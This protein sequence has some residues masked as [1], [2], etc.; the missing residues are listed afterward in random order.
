MSDDDTLLVIEILGH[1]FES[2]A[3]KTKK[4]SLYWKFPEDGG[5]EIEPLGESLPTVLTVNGS[6]Y[7]FG[8]IP[9][10][11]TSSTSEGV[12]AFK[13]FEKA[14]EVRI[15]THIDGHLLNIHC[16]VTVR[17]TGKWNFW[18][19]ARQVR[20]VRQPSNRGG[21]TT[22]SPWDKLKRVFPDE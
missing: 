7:E 13:S 9:K 19:R 21:G 18:F 22:E 17:R 1:T 6:D 12:V 10:R 8:P 16:R 3:M 11:G 20:Q 2:F 14:R 4:G 5:T 15:E